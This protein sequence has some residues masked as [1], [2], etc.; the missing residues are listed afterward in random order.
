MIIFPA[1]DLKEGRCVRLFQG[2]MESATVYNHDPADQAGLFAAAGA[3]HLHVVDLDAAVAGRTVNGQ[4]VRAIR[5]ATEAFLQLGGGVRTLK[6]IEYWLEAG[7][8][9]VILGTA[10]LRDPDLVSQAAQRF[11]GQVAVGIDERD[12]RVAVAGWTE[13][14][15]MAVVTF[16]RDMA[17]RG[18]AAIIHTDINRDG[19]LAGVNLEQTKTLASLVETPVL[20][21]GGVA[22]LAD[23]IAVRDAGNI[24]G[25]ICGRALYD[26]RLELSQAL[27][28]AR[29]GESGRVS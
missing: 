21:S 20:A 1:I 10:A 17:A 18:A 28:S 13:T 2:V 11:P 7:V 16:A 8:D 25:V 27:A 15:S 24:A 3:D 5:A 4:A 12:G 23:I 29:S 14:S 6:D 9:R 19:A 22:R 26:G